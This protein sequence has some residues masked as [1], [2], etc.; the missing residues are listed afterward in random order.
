MEKK[1]QHSWD[2]VKVLAAFARH[3]SVHKAAQ[4]LKLNYTTVM[5]R[6]RSLEQSWDLLL[7]EK[8]QSG[9]QLT[10]Q[11]L[12]LTKRIDQLE[13]DHLQLFEQAKNQNQKL[14]GNVTITTTNTLY[15]SFLAEL[16]EAFKTAHPSISI[17]VDLSLENKDL[18][19][20]QAD[21]AIRMTNTPPDHLAGKQLTDIEFA[22]Y[23]D[24]TLAELDVVPLIVWNKQPEPDFW[25]RQ[26]FPKYKVDMTFN[27]FSTILDAVNKGLGVAMLPRLLVEKSGLSLHQFPLQEKLPQ[28]GL[29]ILFRPEHR[30]IKRISSLKDLLVKELS[31]IR[32]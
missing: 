12:G 1:Q 2:D 19:N 8:N 5:R 21:I 7:L 16:L 28:F 18:A 22:V 24:N 4:E 31:V 32:S 13:M 17:N 26:L 29:W 14:S 11:A 6:L 25:A 27:D 3:N 15:Q 20:S 10:E 30:D 23:G 9:Y